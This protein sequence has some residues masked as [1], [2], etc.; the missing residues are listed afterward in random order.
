M[1]DPYVPVTCLGERMA[2]WDARA[3]AARVLV[4][5]DDPTVAEVVGTYLRRAGHDVDRSR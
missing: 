1:S 4:V 5:E 2:A 3:M